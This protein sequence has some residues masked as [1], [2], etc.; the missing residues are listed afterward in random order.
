M[1]FG[2]KFRA[3]EIEALRNV[4]D[5]VALIGRKRQAA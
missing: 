5:F 3:A 1:R 4:G 2:V